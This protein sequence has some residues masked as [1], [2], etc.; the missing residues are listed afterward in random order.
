MDNSD[1]CLI[2]RN[3]SRALKPAISSVEIDDALLQWFVYRFYRQTDK[4]MVLVILQRDLFA[5]EL[6]INNTYLT[7]RNCHRFFAKYH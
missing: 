5:S 7:H 6:L 3:V 4:E 2:A 1:V